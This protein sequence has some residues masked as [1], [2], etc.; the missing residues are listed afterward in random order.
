MSSGRARGSD[1]VRVTGPFRAGG[2]VPWPPKPNRAS[3]TVWEVCSESCGR[4]DLRCEPACEFAS[5]RYRGAVS[6]FG[7]GGV[8]KH[9][10]GITRPGLFGTALATLRRSSH[11]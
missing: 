4:V 1:S 5:H 6:K 9:R 7:D 3:L 10:L 2:R 11:A 8:L